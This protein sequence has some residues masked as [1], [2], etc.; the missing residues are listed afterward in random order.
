MHNVVIESEFKES[1][2]DQFIEL[3]FSS[4]KEFDQNEWK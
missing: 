4:V 2:T 1:F 3:T